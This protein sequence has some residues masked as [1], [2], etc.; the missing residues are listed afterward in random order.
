MV[1]YRTIFAPTDNSNWFFT[2]FAPVISSNQQNTL[3]E[4]NILLEK[5][6]N[7]ENMDWF[8]ASSVG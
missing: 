1:Y 7:H 5:Q 4:I 2:I 3:F 6:K 8:H